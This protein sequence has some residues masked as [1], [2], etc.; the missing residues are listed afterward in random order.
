MRT[1]EVGLRRSSRTVSRYLFFYTASFHISLVSEARVNE[2]ASRPLW[3][4]LMRMMEDIR[5]ENSLE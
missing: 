3:T 4:M 2:M 1:S 5:L